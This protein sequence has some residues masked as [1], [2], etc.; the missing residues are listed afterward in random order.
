MS[1]FLL[2]LLTGLLM[3]AP[4]YAAEPQDEDIHA[5]TAEGD[6]IILHANGYWEF[7]DAK[8]AEV[9]KAKVE[10]Y[11]RDNNCPAG[12]RPGFLGFGRCIA[13]GEHLAKRGALTNKGR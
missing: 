11:E 13:D 8:K 10:R 9:A 5:K 4:L 12:T 7:K 6:E 2:T 3:A 1:R